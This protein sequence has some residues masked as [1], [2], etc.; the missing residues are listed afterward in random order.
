MVPAP[1]PDGVRVAEATWPDVG[2]DAEGMDPGPDHIVKN[3]G[4]PSGRRFGEGW[5]PVESKLKFAWIVLVWDNGIVW[6]VA[7]TP[8]VRYGV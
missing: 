4:I 5:L 7:V 2:T 6:G 3:T 1:G 8:N